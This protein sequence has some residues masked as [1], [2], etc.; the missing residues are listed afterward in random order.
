MIIGMHICVNNKYQQSLG[1]FVTLSIN[2]DLVT[3]N[4]ICSDFMQDPDDKFSQ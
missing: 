3:S 4:T 1:M 2:A